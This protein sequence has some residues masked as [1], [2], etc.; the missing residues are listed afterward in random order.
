MD[1]TDMLGEHVMV[2]VNTV[3]EI[4]HSCANQHHGHPNKNTGE[5]FLLVWRLSGH[6]AVHQERIA[7]LAALCIIKII[8]K[9]AKSST[10]V[11]YKSH[12]KLQKRLPNFR[13]RMAFGAHQGRAIEGA[14]GT[15]FKLD[16]L[17]LSPTIHVAKSLSH[18]TSEYGCLLLL[19]NAM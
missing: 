14:I 18:A 3:A 2:F 9:I 10:L 7:D 8:A 5:A 17:Y 13:V 6:K 15:E 4:V 16:A 11:E 12:P 1:A 19:T